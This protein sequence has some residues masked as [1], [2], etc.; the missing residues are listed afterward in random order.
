MILPVNWSFFL[1][2]PFST[3][4][5]VLY[6][7]I[8]IIYNNFVCL[9]I[10]F[11]KYKIDE[12]AL[13]LKHSYISFL[14]IFYGLAMKLKVPKLYKAKSIKKNKRT[15]SRFKRNI[16]ILWNST[17]KIPMYKIKQKRATKLKT[18]L[19]RLL[20]RGVLRIQS[21]IQDG[22]FCKSR[23]QLSGFN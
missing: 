17:T 12:K 5:I 11:R 14:Q 3:I 19:K 23:Q 4:F 16:K 6:C 8:S 18:E 7:P 1:Y 13:I 10:N 2:C 15:K 22:D 20:R 9:H 21:N